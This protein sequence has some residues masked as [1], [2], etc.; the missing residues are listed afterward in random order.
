MTGYKKKINAEFINTTR[1]KRRTCGHPSVEGGYLVWIML[2][3]G[4]LSEVT[5]KG[6]AVPVTDV[7][8]LC[9]TH[10][11]PL[12]VL[13]QCPTDGGYLTLTSPWVQVK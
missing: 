6:H 3:V 12:P 4:R 1:C 2:H 10:E 8:T 9:P 7:E 11:V 13:A 5:Y